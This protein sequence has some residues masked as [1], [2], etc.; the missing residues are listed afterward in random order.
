MKT[1]SRFMGIL[2]VASITLGLAASAD[3]SGG[4]QLDRPDFAPA[5]DGEDVEITIWFGR[6]DFLPD[7]AF[8]SFMEQYPHITVK[9]DVVPLEEIPTNFIRQFEAGDAPDIIQPADSAVPALAV[10]GMLYDSTPIIEEW[11]NTNPDLYGVM[12]TSAWDVSAY[13][14]T[15]YGLTLHLAADWNV[16]RPDVLADL[17]L[18]EPETWDDVL[19][20]AEAITE[21]TDMYGYGLDASR[22]RSPDR[23][24]SIF[25]QMGGQWVDGVM[26]IDSEAGHY[27]LNFYQELAAREV[28]DP[29]TIALDFPDYV[30]NFADGR[31]AMGVMSQNVYLEDLEPMMTYGEQWLVR[32]TPYTR[33]GGEA[34]ARY[35]ARGWPYLVSAETEHPYEVGLV[36]QYLATDEQALSVAIRYQPASNTR[37]MASEEYLTQN[38]WGEDLV[39]PSNNLAVRPTHVQQAAMDEV[40]RDAMQDALSYPD[41]DVAEMAA[42]YQAELDALAAEVEE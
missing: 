26:Q 10:R 14:G 5:P 34:E 1:R 9:T 42:R 16:F 25:A 33:P 32:T 37:V 2:G 19:D 7:D 12:S 23:D 22:S 30:Q 31:H 41:T 35:L 20:V 11:A 13:E 8:E 17:G 39:E 29:A 21:Q 28:I 24:K 6:E 38:P 18:E 27:W 40:I 15:P 4:E 3:A 36:L